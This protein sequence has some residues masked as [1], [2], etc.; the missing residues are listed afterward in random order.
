M[1]I[2]FELKYQASEAA[3]AAI[4]QA[5]PQPEVLLQMQTTYYDTPDG[6]LSARRW[7]LRSRLE[8]GRNI[9]TLKIPAGDA[10]Q[11]WETQAEDILSALPVFR[12]MGCP[13]ALFTL[14]EGGLQPI[15]GAR[16]TRIAKTV[17]V[18]D[19]VL[20]IAMDSG[21]LTGGSRQIPLCELEVE[22]KSGREAVCLT[23]ARELARRYGLA[24]EPYSKFR[25]ALDLYKGE[26]NGL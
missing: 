13:E 14:A 20:E 1:G 17:T 19:S 3:F 9:C 22:L 16:F 4:R 15:C 11:E 25:R 26:T 18:E 21:V 24:E 10:R 2:E 23:F 5:Y 8:N 6:S 7:T 12:E